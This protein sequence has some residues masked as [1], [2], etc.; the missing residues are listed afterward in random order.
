MKPR[1]SSRVSR[2]LSV[3]RRWLRHAWISRL[4]LGQWRQALGAPRPSAPSSGRLKPANFHP[5]MEFFEPRFM[6]NDP[7]GLMQTA[8]IGPAFSLLTPSAVLFRGWGADL[9]RTETRPAA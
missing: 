6:P 4:P 5:E 3:L 9:G 2:A 1:T 7:F 8:L